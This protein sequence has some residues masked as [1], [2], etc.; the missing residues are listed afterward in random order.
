MTAA[1]GL[2]SRRRRQVGTGLQCTQRV[3]TNCLVNTGPSLQIS[4]THGKCEA[5]PQA[6]RQLTAPS[7]LP[8][9]DTPAPDATFTA[10]RVI[11]ALRAKGRSLTS[12][13]RPATGG[14]LES[15]GS[16]HRRIHRAC[17]RET[18]RGR[19]VCSLRS[20]GNKTEIFLPM[21]RRRSPGCS[22]G[23][24]AVNIFR[25]TYSGRKQAAHARFLTIPAGGGMKIGYARASTLDQ[26]PDL[27]HDAL[28]QAPT[29][30]DAAIARVFGQVS[31]AVRGRA[32][33]SSCG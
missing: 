11:S 10:R 4:Q 32:R 24:S 27:P 2:R 15:P 12:A 33:R 9:R 23:H 25:Q 8:A 6:R 22:K 30:Q 7:G 18:G 31:H 16:R 14:F 21:R 19:R 3:T 5:V 26:N 28:T 13:A 1:P 29:S 20:V 17:S